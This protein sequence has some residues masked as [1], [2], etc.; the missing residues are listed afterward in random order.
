MTITAT[1]T[2][3]L[4]RQGTAMQLIV[5]GKPM[6]VLGGELSN[7]AATSPADIEKVMSKMKGIGLNTVL[8]PAQWDLL[9]PTEGHFDFTLVD[10]V[11]NNARK[12]QLKIIFLWFGAWKNSMSCYAPLWFK[13]N[14]RKYPR[15]CTAMGKTLEIASTFSKDVMEADKNAFCHLMQHIKEV[16]SKE[17]TVIMVQVENEIGMLES[18]RDHS[19]LA[20]KAYKEWVSNG[21][22]RKMAYDFSLP[23]DYQDEVFQAYHYAKYVEQLASAGKHIYNI[24]LY[25]NAAMNSRGRTPGQYPSAGPLAHLIYI[26]K[27]CAPSID[28]FTPDIYDTGFKDWVTKYDFTDR[29]FFTPETR[30]DTNSGVKAVYTIGATDAIGYSVFAID[31]ASYK[32]KCSVTDGYTMLN[33]LSPLLLKWQGLKPMW[34]VLFDQEDKERIIDDNGTIITARHYYTLPWDPRA[35][36]GSK[37]PEG[38]ALVMRLAKNEYVIAGRG[39]VVTF[40]TR[41]EQAQASE[42]KRGEDG[43]IAASDGETTA[44]DTKMKQKETNGMFYGRRLGLGYVDQVTVDADGNMQY[45]RR[46]NGDQDHQ[47]RHARISCDGYKI[48]HIKLYEY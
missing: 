33:T 6:L 7:S 35:S 12:R 17:T 14:T 37:W 15:A 40:Q 1:A 18:A 34:G 20:E 25:V 9:E 43:F 26:W 28:L 30:L 29:P 44:N 10:E 41:T 16:D 4:K 46:D 3:C 23:Q 32:E 38:G 5:N 2:S 27:Q 19:P 47:G 31:Q 22:D 21:M 11:I 24:P 13:E 8:V 39:V 42:L 48:L 36:D 45:V